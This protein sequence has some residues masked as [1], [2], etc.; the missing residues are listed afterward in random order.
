MDANSNVYVADQYNNA[1]RKI[2]P[3]AGTTNWVVTTIA[4][5]GPNTN[6][7]ADGTNKAAQF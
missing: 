3:V 1:I 2:T 7:V 4:G 5:Q 6:G